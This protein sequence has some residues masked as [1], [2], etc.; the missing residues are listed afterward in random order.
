MRKR[1]F[2]PAASLPPIIEYQG[3]KIGILICEDIWH[4]DVA[5]HL[6]AQGAK[7]FIV[8]NGSPYDIDKMAKR[9]DYASARARDHRCPLIYVNQVGGQDE[10]VF[11]G[12]FFCDE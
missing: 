1:I 12:G 9:I 2:E 6:A 8:P 3:T 10:L 4:D 7:I 5:A 11:D